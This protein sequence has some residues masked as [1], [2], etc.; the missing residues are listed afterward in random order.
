MKF[1]RYN[2]IENVTRSKTMAQIEIQGINITEW[3]VLEK[4]HGANFSVWTDGKEV[5]FA[6]RSG[7]F[8]DSFYNSHTIT[9]KLTT[10]I[11]DAFKIANVAL[12]EP[13]ET[14]AVYGE[15]FGGNFTHPDVKK[16]DVSSIQKGIQYCPDINFMA[17]DMMVNG[18]YVDHDIFLFI[19]ER[20]GFFYTKTRFRGT[21]EECLA[22]SN[23]YDSTIPAQLGLPHLTD[24]VCEGN[25]IKPTIVTYF[26]NGERVILKDKNEKWSEKAKEKKPIKE[27]TKLTDVGKQKVEDMCSF[28]SE[29]RLRNVL[30]K[31][32]EVTNKD[33]GK[34]LGDFMLDIIEDYEKEFDLPELDKKEAK[35]VNKLVNGEAA[36]TIRKNFRDICDNMF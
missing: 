34:I 30:S 1:K 17:F 8:T 21:L 15:L 10:N 23:T 5:Q 29:N 27:I 20:S 3:V 13:C 4:V 18:Q 12:K 36:Q 33:F 19:V 35:L 6:K 28:I 26:G 2:S 25:V 22:Q 11:F 31:I 14:L 16:V 9:E 7:F 24:N 32:G